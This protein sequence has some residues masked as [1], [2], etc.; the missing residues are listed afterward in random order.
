MAERDV[1]R[2]WLDGGLRQGDPAD[3]PTPP[4]PPPT[5]ETTDIARMAEPYMP[6]ATAPDDYRCFVLDLEF[7]TDQF[8]TGRAVIPGAAEIV[9]HVLSYAV[10]PDQLAIVEAADAADDGPGYRCFGGPLPQ[11]SE[12]SGNTL[13]LIN[14]GGWVPGSLPALARP[15]RAAWIPAGSRIVMQVHYNLLSTDPEPDSTEMHLQLT[16]VEPEFLVRSFP[17]A[18]LDLDIRAGVPAAMHRQVF[19]NYTTEPMQLTGFTPHMHMLGSEIRAQQVP[20]F[21]T[22]GP[23]AC[24]IDIPNWRFNWQQGYGVREDAPVTLEPGAGIELTC[25]YDNST[26]NQPVVNGEQLEPRN[27]TWGEGS[28][29]EMCLMYV[30]HEVPW[31][32][33]LS[34]GC[35][36]AN[37]CLASCATTDIECLY[38]CE[39]IAGGCRACLLQGTLGCAQEACFATYVPAGTCMQSCIG[40]YSMLGGSFERCMETECPAEWPAVRDC[41]SGFVDAGTCDAELTACGLVR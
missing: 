21:G 36:A 41:V 31:T 18:I 4:T 28:L 1:F 12:D 15:G 9:H 23:N 17:T 19:R 14:L 29:D 6:D 39:N 16:D 2:R 33:P 40:S 10:S 13:G 30:Q 37:E 26:F 24:L 34:G 20:A 27:V 8:M 38:A 25:I 11:E 5:L 3:A 22:D 35:D 7:P 32:G